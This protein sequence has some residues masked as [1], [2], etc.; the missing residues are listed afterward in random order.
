[1]K[2][3]LKFSVNEVL[4]YREKWGVVAY[5]A[6]LGILCVAI[7]IGF[8]WLLRDQA[9]APKTF[10]F[11]CCTLFGLAGGTL[12][13]RLPAKAKQII[14]SDGAHV[15]SAGP[16]GISVTQN[17]GAKRRSAM[18]SAIA[19]VV[20]A[21]KL[22]SI[23]FG[24]TGYAWRRVIVFLKDEYETSGFL[25]RVES[26]VFRSGSGRPY[27]SAPYPRGQGQSLEDALHQYAPPSVHVRSERLVVFDFKT[28]RDS[29]ANA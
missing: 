7:G 4:I 22:G 6:V 18:W 26:G 23:E 2:L 17:L 15:L 21:E 12:L 19:E 20:L 11:A 28:H 1:M 25:D 13:L 9:A 10:L 14:G 3:K 5:I 27:L 16:E 8:Y 29:Y 24:E